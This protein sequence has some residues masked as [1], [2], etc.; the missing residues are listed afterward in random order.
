MKA[1]T[2]N[3]DES[4][5]LKLEEV[6]KPSI[7]PDEVLIA[8]RAAAL[9]HRDLY[10]TKQWQPLKGYGTFIAGGDASGVIVEIGSSVSGWML[11]DEVIINP[12]LVDSEDGP[13]FPP[14]LGGPTDGTFAEFVKA[15]A[16]FILK[17]P[18]YLT[19][20]E[21]AA[22]PLALSTAWGNTSVQG[23]LQSGETLLLQGIGGGVAT[24]ILQM[25]VK[26]GVKVIV[27]SS[28]DE[29]IEKAIE[30]GASYGINYK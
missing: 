30:L 19:F 15:P 21:A 2:V 5:S 11:G 6:Q 16:A 25:A 14:F 29:K 27:T 13:N 22:L 10:M 18:K 9:N 17:K 8:V 3:I 23:K 26:M 24:F 4:N 1:V 20:E 28:S 7:G 12:L